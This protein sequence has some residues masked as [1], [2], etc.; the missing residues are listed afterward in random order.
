MD[1]WKVESVRASL[2]ETCKHQSGQRIFGID[3]VLSK[4]R[5]GLRKNCKAIERIAKEKFWNGEKGR[6]GF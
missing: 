1:Q 4:V 3:G 5:M 6:K 2:A